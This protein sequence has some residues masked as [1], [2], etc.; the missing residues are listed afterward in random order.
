MSFQVLEDVCIGCG[1]CD[2]SCPTGSLTKT[3]S[4]L[5]LFVIDPFTCNDCGECVPKCPVMAIVA[6]PAW[7]VCGGHGCPLTSHRLE[8][9]DCSFWQQRCPQCGT[10]L[11]HSASQGPAADCPRCGWGLKVAC[12]RTRMLPAGA[13][14]SCEPVGEGHGGSACGHETSVASPRLRVD[15]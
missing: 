15:S 4:F 1:A 12:P 2:F 9:V 13:R 11:W 8:G 14:G 7:P 6:D 5:G 3:D 10:T